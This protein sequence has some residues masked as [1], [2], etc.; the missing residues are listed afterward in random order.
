MIGSIIAG[1]GSITY[2]TNY[3][4][5]LSGGG[6]NTDKIAYS[7]DGITWSGVPDTKNIINTVCRGIECDI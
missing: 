4:L 2:S 6:T 7:K 1:I 5:W 3:D